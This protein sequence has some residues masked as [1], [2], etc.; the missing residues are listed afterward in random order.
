ME[1]QISPNDTKYPLFAIQGKKF[2]I[3]II[4]TFKNDKELKVIGIYN[5]KYVVCFKETNGGEIILFEFG[6]GDKNIFYKNFS[7]ICKKHNDCQKNAKII[8]NDTIFIECFH[9]DDYYHYSI[10]NLSNEKIYETKNYFYGRS[11]PISNE[12]INEWSR[13][14]LPSTADPNK[15]VD[16]VKVDCYNFVTGEGQFICAFRPIPGEMYLHIS[17]S[18]DF[19][20]LFVC[21]IL[22]D[23]TH[24]SVRLIDSQNK[25]G[26]GIIEIWSIARDEMMCPI[27]IQEPY[28]IVFTK[29]DVI[30]HNFKTEKSWF[31][32]FN[33]KDEKEEDFIK[34]KEGSFI[35]NIKNTLV[36]WNRHTVTDENYLYLNIWDIEEGVS[37]KSIKVD[38]EKYSKSNPPST[39]LSNSN[40][41]KLYI[42]NSDNEIHILNFN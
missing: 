36:H 4:E 26:D 35:T 27:K 23:K 38:S 29:L 40:N 42:L 14:S 20:K 18:R 28:L 39:I 31:I 15:K 1:A 33:K 24:I 22:N 7:K 30:I 25:S 19:K 12:L 8:D 6:C 41:S 34:I 21:S 10:F 37:I 3:E 5:E 17:T 13:I 2:Q 32:D 9:S 11:F 16:L